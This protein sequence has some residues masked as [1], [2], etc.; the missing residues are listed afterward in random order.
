MC[1][2]NGIYAYHHAANPIDQDELVSTR[3]YMQAR[4]LSGC[5]L[6]TDADECLGIG[7]RRL[8][9]ILAGSGGA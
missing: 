7:H 4:G 1:A 8:A 5:G 2:I 9:I 6:W 3:D